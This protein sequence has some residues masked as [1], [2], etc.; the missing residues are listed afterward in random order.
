M[1][2]LFLSL[3]GLNVF[4]NI[5]YMFLPPKHQY[6]VHFYIAGTTITF[7]FIVSDQTHRVYFKVDTRKKVS[8]YG[9]LIFILY[10]LHRGNYLIT[11]LAFLIP[12]A[13][14]YIYFQIRKSKPVTP[15]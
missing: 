9:L 3:F 4:L 6:K 11:A 14:H 7:P 2:R 8:T 5:L 13:I 1:L 12:I 15:S 10:N